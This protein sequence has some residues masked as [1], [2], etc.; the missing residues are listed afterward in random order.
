MNERVFA[1]LLA[2]GA[3]TRFWPLSRRS[4]PKQVLP[5][6]GEAPMVRATLARLGDLVPP[7][8]VLVVTGEDQA[9]AVAGVLPEIPPENL[10]LEP[11]PRNTAPCIGLAAVEALGREPDAVLLCLPADHVMRP[12]A[13][14]REA[15][16]RALARADGAGTLVTFGIE[17]TRPATGYGYIRRGEE[18]AP[19]FFRVEEFREKPARERAEEYLAAGGYLWNS[20]MFAWRADVFLEETDRYMPENGARFALLREDPSRRADLFPRMEPRSVDYGI[21]ERT[22]RAEVL[23]LALRWDDVGSFAA[24]ARLVPGDEAGN[25]ATGEL[26]ALDAHGLVTVAPEGHLVAA[27]GVDD[28]VVVVTPDA[29]LVCPRDRAEEVKS[30]VAGLRRAGRED[31]A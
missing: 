10:V 14:F 2:G 7:E 22:D 21:L 16:A 25:H 26:L 24:L 29:T 13:G 18:T 23:P 11:A 9:A 17:P 27:L 20:G 6:G 1:V 28:L 19:G 5:V 31:L 30:L 4:R 8:R 12:A 15:A 3:G